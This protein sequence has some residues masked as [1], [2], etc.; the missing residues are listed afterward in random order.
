MS[1]PPTPPRRALVT[2]AA[3][4]IGAAIAR[5][6]AA[7]GHRLVLHTHANREGCAALAAELGASWFAADL[8][9]AAA[10]EAALAPFLAEAPFQIVVHNAGVHDDAPLAGMSAARWRRVIGVS[11]DGFHAVL[12][13]VLLPMIGTRWGRI[14]AIS[15]ISAWLPRR[16]QTAYAAAKAGLDAA[17]RALSLELGRR[18]ITVNAIAPGLIES[19]ATERFGPEEVARLVPLGR[20]GKPEEV[21]ALAAFLVSEEAGYITGETIAVAGGLPGSPH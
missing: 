15:S 7:L 18:G 20:K 21:A 12:A 19:P 2:G 17:V 9:D 16:G 1:V 4:P 8:T 10:T 5:R 3:S 14:L 6:L 13:P 11:L